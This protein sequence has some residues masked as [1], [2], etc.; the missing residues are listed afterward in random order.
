ME[1]MGYIKRQALP[2]I[3]QALQR[4]KSIL[5]LGPR[6][7]GKS[8][9]IQTL[10]KDL[11]LSFVQADVRQRYELDPNLLR[12]EVEGLKPRRGRQ[13]VVLL[14]EIQKVPPILNVVQ[15]LID[16]HK[17]IFV[18]TGSSARKLRR[19]P[20]VNLLPGRV[21][22]IRLDPLSLEE[23]SSRTL[24]SRLLYGDLPGIVLENAAAH[25]ET[26]LSSYV[27]TYLEEEI[28]A[29]SIVRN[30]ASFSRFLELAAAESGLVVNQR[31]LSQDI[32][33]A[34]TTIGDYYEILIDCLIA[35]RV[36]PFTQSAT[37]K[38]LTRSPR[39][40]FFDLGV[41]RL[42]AHE[43]PRLPREKMGMLFEQWV[44]LEIIRW[45]RNRLPK[46]SLH[47]W[48]DPDG[49]EVDW[50]V[51]S[52]DTLIPIEVKWTASPSVSDARHLEVFLKEYPQA[53]RGYIVCQ[54]PRRMKLGAAIEAIPWQ[55]L[56][57]LFL[58]K[59]GKR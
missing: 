54:T 20:K 51:S 48:R 5:L 57:S 53:K 8:T 3:E 59:R 9:L 19:G 34:H 47:F 18:L 44:G 24:E 40:L 1:L 23:D 35:E 30:L 28:R 58:E 4:G 50:V 41:R 33:V 43:G 55:E 27:T 25:Q 2:L 13:P 26:D 49:P 7:T 52:A 45:S 37:R 31:H 11:Y 6:Q 56:P 38:K 36:E 12:T 16:R 29:E 46:M 42:A 32:G 22:S 21:V 17:A 15:D 39:M 14:D 10:P